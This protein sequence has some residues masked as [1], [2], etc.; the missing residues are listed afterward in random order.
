ML[1][2]MLTTKEITVCFKE[3]LQKCLSMLCRPLRN[4]NLQL[5][6][7]YYHHAGAEE[8]SRKSFQVTT[9]N[10][11]A[12]LWLIILIYRDSVGK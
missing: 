3:K 1:K 2:L 5:V 7:L 6:H 9:A 4:R 12:F 10:R 8:T 11:N